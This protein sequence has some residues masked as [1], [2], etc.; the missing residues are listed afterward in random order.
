M[1]IV[2][3][4]RGDIVYIFRCFLC[5]KSISSVT[6][7][8]K[9]GILGSRI[10]DFFSKKSDISLKIGQIWL[11]TYYGHFLDEKWILDIFCF[12]ETLVLLYQFSWKNGCNFFSSCWAVH[13]SMGGVW[14]KWG[15][16]PFLV[17][18]FNTSL[19]GLDAQLLI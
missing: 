14:A 9:L 12:L 11:F 1:D 4:H 10:P 16:V 13:F 7:F 17:L 18:F 8:L 2:M 15:P 6:Q 5:V 19:G 3:C